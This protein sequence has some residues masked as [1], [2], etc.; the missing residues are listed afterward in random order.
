M[1]HCKISRS[2]NWVPETS[3]NLSNSGSIWPLG[4]TLKPKWH[5]RVLAKIYLKLEEIKWFPLRLALSLVSSSYL[6]VFSYSLKE[7]EGLINWA[8]QEVI[9]NQDR[10][11][12]FPWPNLCLILVPIC[13]VHQKN[14]WCQRQPKTQVIS[15]LNPWQENLCSALFLVLFY[16]SNPVSW[17]KASNLMFSELTILLCIP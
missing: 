14:G 6:G 4:E 8:W 2:W 1:D 10:A 7:L 16:L 13:T 5:G 9:M 17:R 12:D 11:T 15:I 3:S